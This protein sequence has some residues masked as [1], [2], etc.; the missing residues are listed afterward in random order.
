MTQIFTH[1]KIHKFRRL[2]MMEL[3]G[4][5]QV[6]ILVGT[7]NSGKTSLLEAISLICNPLDP[8]QWLE[9]SQRRL[10]LGRASLAYRPNLEALKWVFPQEDNSYITNSYQGEIAIDVEGNAPIVRLKAVLSDIYGS[11]IE[12]SSALVNEGNSLLEEEGN[13]LLEETEYVLLGV[14]LEVIAHLNSVQGD[15]F[16]SIPEQREA[17]QF[18]EDERFIQRKRI[19]PFVKSTTVSPSYASYEPILDRLTRVILQKETGKDEVLE[20][21]GWL[22]DDIH[23]IFIG[24]PQAKAAIYINHKKLGRAPLYTFGD[25]IKRTLLIALTLLSTENGV[26]LIDE[27][28][29]SIHVSALSKVFVWLV[30]ACFRKNIQLFVTTHSLEAIDAMLQTD[31]STESIVAFRLN[32]EG[33]SLQRFAGSVLHRLRSERGLD[34][35]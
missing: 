6:N 32:D 4:L 12:S 30:K 20:V 19:R 2:S 25:G 35:R 27:I 28:E 33:R 13:S 16:N 3:S 7:N 5:G 24:A 23:D 26:L 11:R 1:L 21:L 29:T 31:I 9:V 34:V 14:E 17:F 10:Y 22:D 18:W 15:L 8:F